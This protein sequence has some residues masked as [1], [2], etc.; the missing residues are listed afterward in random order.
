MPTSG[1]FPFA[2]QTPHAVGRDGELQAIKE[3]LE[4]PGRETAILYFIGPGGI[5]KTRLIE[6]GAKLAPPAVLVSPVIDLYH[7][8]AHSVAGLQQ[9]LADGLDPQGAR[10]VAYRA[11]SADI[12]RRRAGGVG[13]SPEERAALTEVF[14]QDYQDLASQQRL[15]LR[16]DTTELI[17]RESDR[18]QEVCGLETSYLEIHDWLLQVLPSLPNTVVLLAGRPPAPLREE[19]RALAEQSGVCSFQDFELGGLSPTACAAY[20]AELQEQEPRLLDIP[21]EV[22]ALAWQ[23]SEGHPIRL[24]LVI[25]LV[26]NGRD[27][28]DLFPLHYEASAASAGNLPVA[29][30]DKYL[31]EELHSIPAESYITLHYLALARKGLDAGLLHTLEPEWPLEEC[32]ARL[33]ALRRFTFIKGHTGTA[34]LFIH[35]ELYALFDRYLLRER[36]EYAETYRRIYHTY[37]QRLASEP[38]SAPLLKPDALYYALQMDPWE[39]FWRVYLPWAEE[40]V[41]AGDSALD[42][43]LRDALLHFLHDSREDAWVARRLPAALL[44]RDAAVRWCR[45]YLGQG[46]HQR[47]IE[48]AQRIEASQMLQGDPLYAAALTVVWA[49]AALYVSEEE[50]VEGKLQ[51]ARAALEAW[52]PEGENDPRSWWR[53]RLLG[54]ARNNLGYYYWALGQNKRAMAEYKRAIWHFREADIKDEMAATLTN[55][56]FIY[57]QLGLAIEAEATLQDAISLRKSGPPVPLAY[58]LN[59]LGLAY[60]YDDRPGQGARR[61]KEALKIFESL[62]HLRGQGLAHLALG[63]AYRVRG[64][65]WKEGLCSPE[66]AE[67]F[68]KTAQEHLERAR[69]IFAG[70][71]QEPVRLWEAHNELGSLYCDWGW[72]LKSHPEMGPTEEKYQRALDSLKASIQVA[73]GQK[74][75]GR[76]LADSYD[77]LSQVYGDMGDEGAGKE[78]VERVLALI[79]KE[80]RLTSEGFAHAPEWPVEDWWQLLGKVHLGRAVRNIKQV[81]DRPNE[82]LNAEEK[83]QLLDRAAEEY[84]T[85]VAYFQQ[86]SPYSVLLERTLKSI[87]GRIKMLNATQ[88][89]RMYHIIQQFAANHKVNL[90]RLLTLLEN[91]AGL[92]RDS[93]A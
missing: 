55:L 68:F 49:E 19:L 20:L 54:R 62:Q 7:A 31:M 90:E 59:T 44:E 75:L 34:Q 89:R 35:D 66:E 93:S 70:Q 63:L 1:T 60:T 58:S 61:C 86:Y 21:E 10:F 17:Q 47:A 9:L 74:D 16:F 84:A 57:V 91:T 79:P 29:D 51:E 39:G 46:E 3:A 41:R 78:Y 33:D 2:P 27:I 85:A 30:I 69:T 71:V 14:L 83:E 76:R 82:A 24:S 8:E 23:Y 87:Q 88:V 77:D 72:L 38:S 48:I 12:E 45:R 26:L 40:A 81:V 67:D 52:T 64:E 22:W 25:D 15:A 32:Q 6:E 37:E 18:V 56:G 53:S 13:I 50:P 73:E 65:E 92:E 43:R 4:N 5:G 11:K 42:M 80:Y 28:A 36:Q